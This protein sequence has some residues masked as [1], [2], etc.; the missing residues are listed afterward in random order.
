MVLYQRRLKLLIRLIQDVQMGIRLA[1]RLQWLPLRL[2]L[3]QMQAVKQVI[4]LANKMLSLL[5]KLPPMPQHV[6]AMTQ[7]V[8]MQ[9][10]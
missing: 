5:L 3:L 7:H 4:R 8:K 2:K 1:R 10:L 9:Q 6:R